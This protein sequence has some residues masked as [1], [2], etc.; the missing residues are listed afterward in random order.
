MSA[1][2]CRNIKPKREDLRPTPLEESAKDAKEEIAAAKKNDRDEVSPEHRVFVRKSGK[3]TETVGNERSMYDP[4]IPTTIDFSGVL[5]DLPKKDAKEQVQA[6]AC[7][8]AEFEGPIHIDRLAKLTANYFGVRQLRKKKK[9]QI[10]RQ[11]RNTDLVIDGEKFVWPEDIDYRDWTE[12]RPN[13]S[14]VCRDFNDIS[15]FEI[16]NAFIFLKDEGLTGEELDRQVLQTFGKKRRTAKIKIRLN[17]ARALARNRM[18][19][20]V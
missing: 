4:W 2:T 7:E 13:N 14:D 6:V 17:E 16:A 5:D 12:F 9:E 8:I 15:L 20:W 19:N 10:Q 11:I 3:T 1:T 18:T